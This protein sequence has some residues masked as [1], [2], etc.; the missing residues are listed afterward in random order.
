MKLRDVKIKTEKNL[1]VWNFSNIKFWMVLILMTQCKEWPM[2]QLVS[3]MQLQRIWT[4]TSSSH[5]D[6]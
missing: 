5:L 3:W 6:I 4:I 2:S 1:D